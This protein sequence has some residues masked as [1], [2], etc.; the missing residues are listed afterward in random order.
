MAIKIDLEKACDRLKWKFVN[1]TLEDIG[2]PTSIIDRMWFCMSTPS[3]CA[4]WN[5]EAL[6]EFMPSR[7]IH[8]GDRHWRISLFCAWSA[9][10]IL[11]ISQLMII[12]GNRCLPRQGGLRF[13]IWCLRMTFCLQKPLW[14]KGGPSM[15]A[16]WWIGVLPAMAFSQRACLKCHDSCGFP[17]SDTLFKSI[18]RWEGPERIR[19]FL[20]KVAHQALM[21]NTK[22][23]CHHFSSVKR[24]HVCG[25]QDETLFH[26]F[27]DSKAR[28]PIWLNPLS[29]GCGS[30][31][32]E[33]DW[34]AWML[35]NL[36]THRQQ[37]P[38]A[39]GTFILQLVYVHVNWQARNDLVFS[40]RSTFLESMYWKPRTR[41][42]LAQAKGTMDVLQL[43][44]LGIPTLPLA[45]AASLHLVLFPFVVMEL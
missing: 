18:W 36:S 1:E 14:I 24:W 28:S 3:T 23:H 17:S 5:G 9:F 43:E 32:S 15:T 34:E 12:T 39:I 42:S 40:N 4:L 19:L 11:L 6:D 25:N 38:F 27:Q 26:A 35:A 37:Q 41:C 20:W 21:V 7:G 22:W 44:R 16:M 30:F 8:Q 2:F 29:N 10:S 33:R 13:L 31:F 45:N